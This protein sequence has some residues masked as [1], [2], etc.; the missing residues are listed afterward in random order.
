MASRSRRTSGGTANKVIWF[1]VVG[2]LILAFFQIPYDPGVKGI[3]GVVQ[4]KA[5]TVKTWAESVGPAIGEFAEGI[6]KGGGSMV[7]P[8]VDPGDYTPYPENSTGT[9][10]PPSEV[11][12]SLNN[13]V[14]AEP[15]NVSYNRDEWNHWVDV[16]PCWTVRE[17]VLVNSAVPGSLELKNS[18]GN[19]TTSVDD[20][21]EIVSGKWVDPYSN[22]EFTNPSDLDIDHMIPLNYAAQHG[23]QGWDSSRKENYANSLEPG[24]LVAASA[25]ENR[26]KGDKGPSVWKPS[27]QAYY[28]QYATSWVNVANSWGL[29]ITQADHDALADMLTTCK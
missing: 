28:C 21:C 18:A 15:S 11:S 7:N 9:S 13:I 2:G 20:A 24:H 26:S 4:G 12:G 1:L 22:K 17:L 10:Q 8:D 25:S 29:T 14:I 27:N 16:R 6:I 5:D 3:M 23:G 19:P